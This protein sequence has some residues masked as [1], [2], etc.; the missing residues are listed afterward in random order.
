MR[1]G[2]LCRRRITGTDEESADC[3]KL[4]ADW[5][6]C[7]S[8]APAKY[9]VRIGNETQEVTGNVN[10]F[11]CSPQVIMA[12]WRIMNRKELVLTVI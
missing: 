9:M 3:G 6:E 11:Y 2:Q 12:W 5:S 10:S 1:D 7:S 8:A 4:T